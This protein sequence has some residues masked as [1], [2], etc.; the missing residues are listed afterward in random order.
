MPSL[1]TLT[2]VKPFCGIADADT[3]HDTI[4]TNIVDSVEARFIRAV[5]WNV[6]SG[7]H[8]FYFCGNGMTRHTFPMGP[9][10]AITSL[11][12]Q[13]D[14][15][16]WTTIDSDEYEIITEGSVSYLFYPGGFG[17]GTQY[18]AVTTTG[19]AT[20]PS[21][22]QRLIA[23][24]ASIDY[25]KHPA[26]GEQ[27]GFDTAQQGQNANGSSATTVYREPEKLWNETVA[28]YRRVLI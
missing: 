12:S 26:S 8:T 1:T 23:I 11:A 20:V 6:A 22:V 9:V 21:D 24:Y 15:G 3:N 17:L 16:D 14:V 18:R 4:L 2:F 7:S 28:A 5:G 27:R 13:D 10:T 25:G 19:F